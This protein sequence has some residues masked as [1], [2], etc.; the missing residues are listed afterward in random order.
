M[1]R[2]FLNKTKPNP[3]DIWYVSVNNEMVPKEG[4]QEVY[5]K[6]GVFVGKGNYKNGVRNGFWQFFYPNGKISDCGYYGEDGLRLSI[7][8]YADTWDYY[9]EDGTKITFDGDL[10]REFQDALDSVSNKMA[11]DIFK[12]L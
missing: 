3:E 7:K 12:D 10:P 9:K 1:K 4:Y 11:E 2:K 6:E 5:D 8:E